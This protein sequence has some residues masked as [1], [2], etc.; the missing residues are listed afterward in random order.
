[1]ANIQKK[2][3]QGRKTQSKIFSNMRKDPIERNNELDLL[4]LKL[5]CGR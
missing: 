3:L 2:N 4:L 1:M 5:S